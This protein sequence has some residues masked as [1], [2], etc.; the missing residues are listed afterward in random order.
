MSR[1]ALWITG[2]LLPLGLVGVLIALTLTAVSAAQDEEE[3]ART[4]LQAA[5]P[6]TSGQE[7]GRTGSGSG[8]QKS[9]RWNSEQRDNAKVI[10]A[11]AKKRHL[12]ARAAQIALATAMQE[13]GLRNLGHGDRDS[14][15]LFQQRPSQGWGTPAQV[16]EPAYAAGQFYDRLVK[17]RG[18]RQMPLTRAAQ[19]V[20]RSLYPNAYAR[21]ETAAEQLVEDYW[22][23]AD[24]PDVPDNA[25]PGGEAADA[26]E[27]LGMCQ[28]D[29]DDGGLPDVPAGKRAQKA[30]ATARAAIGTP[31]VWGGGNQHGPTHGGY[32]CSGL[33]QHAI[34]TATGGKTLLPRTSQT[35]KN[36][37][38]HVPK[39]RMRPGD[40][41]VI[42]N[43][44][45]WGHVGLYAGNHHMI[46][47]P[48]TGKTV[49]E[50]SLT[51][52]WEQF[53]WEVRRVL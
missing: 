23:G 43:D 16:R 7:T 25:G 46:H 49:E 29:G 39:D 6:N 20:Q 50:T 34:Y 17:V 40:L 38:R 31:Y 45:N 9:G 21:W 52:Y 47:A 33:T 15:G 5:C 53:P 10:I 36:A 51:G 11:V 18:W 44:G 30:L 48:R 8:P 26:N 12:P 28:P 22:T 14:L 27:P 41:I 13:S 2:A 42:N 24:L 19:K 3:A 37:G 1:R 35:Q 4:A 32:D